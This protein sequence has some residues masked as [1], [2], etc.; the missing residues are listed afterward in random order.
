MAM[1]ASSTAMA[2]MDMTATASG[3][4]ASSTSMSDMNMDGMMDMGTCMVSVS[5]FSNQ[6]CI[7]DKAWIPQTTKH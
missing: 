2:G 1:M 5:H 7:S 6:Y 4:M 3:S